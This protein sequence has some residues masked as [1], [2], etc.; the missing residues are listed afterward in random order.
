MYLRYKN[1]AVRHRTRTRSSI[2]IIPRSQNRVEIAI[3]ESFR[4]V[5]MHGYVGE[6]ANVNI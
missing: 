3:S 2:L 6:N 1:L 4:D 5:T